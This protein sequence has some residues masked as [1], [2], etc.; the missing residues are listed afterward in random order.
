MPLI[1]LNNV[2]K[3]FHT[4]NVSLNALKSI[5]LTINDG[6]F[7]AVVGPS[8]SGKTTLMNILGLLDKPTTGTY[9]LDGKDVLKLS[10][11]TLAKL[12]NQKIGFVFQNFN[13]LNRTSS[14][15]NVALPLIYTGTPK[16]KRLNLAID[17]LK[18]LGLKDKVNA[19]P[20]QLSGG[21]QQRV[22]IARALVT[23]P[24]IILADEPTGNLDSKTG[25][26]IINLLKNLNKRGKTI[27]LITHDQSI[28][29]Q[30]KRVIHMKDGQLTNNLK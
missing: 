17:T 12:R 14:V 4:S 22:A 30:A 25:F 3:T 21:Q 20:N 19:H 24:A 13:L 7:L 26:E 1:K 2:N 28:T 27:V 15:D 6:E 10:D 11:N 18:Q 8:G 5:N 16:D 23:D 29:G 9:Q